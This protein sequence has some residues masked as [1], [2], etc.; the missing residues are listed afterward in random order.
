VNLSASVASLILL[1]VPGDTV[2]KL[3]LESFDVQQNG[4]NGTL[5]NTPANLQTSFSFENKGNL[6]IGPFGILSVKQG[7]KVVYQTTFNDQNPRDVILPDSS[8]RSVPSA[9][10]MSSRRLPTVRKTKPSKSPNRS[11]SFH[12]GSSSRQSVYLLA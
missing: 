10:T 5:F 7:D 1:T 4:T 12:N 3:S 2:E 9:T 8:R 11:G 6:Q